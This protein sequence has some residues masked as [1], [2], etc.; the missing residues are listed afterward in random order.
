MVLDVLEETCSDLGTHRSV[1]LEIG[2]TLS[3][4]SGLLIYH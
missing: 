4:E 3:I 1:R 2:K